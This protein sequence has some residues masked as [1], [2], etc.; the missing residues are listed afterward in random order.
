MAAKQW[1]QHDWGH[2]ATQA[3]FALAD[4]IHTHLQDVA[5]RLDYLS[6]HSPV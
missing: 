2:Q 4:V 3:W 5:D 6:S 1:W